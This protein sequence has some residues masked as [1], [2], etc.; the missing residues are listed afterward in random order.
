MLLHAVRPDDLI[1]VSN[2]IAMICYLLRDEESNTLFRDS[3]L[4]SKTSP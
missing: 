1:E 2:R 3:M 4:E